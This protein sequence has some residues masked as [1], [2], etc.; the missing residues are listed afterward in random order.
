M[1]LALDLDDTLY[2]EASYVDSGLQAVA[3]WCEQQFGWP[4]GPSL[5]LLQRRESI[6]WPELVYVGDNPAKD[7]V[8]LRAVGAR[9]VRERTGHHRDVVAR[10]GHVAEASIGS[11]DELD[12]CLARLG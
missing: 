7:F 9:T 3:R 11:L 4:A 1:V 12:V 5:A 2:P 8:A 10:P 6:D